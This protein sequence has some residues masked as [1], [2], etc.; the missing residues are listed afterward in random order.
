M[1]YSWTSRLNYI[2]YNVMALMAFCGFLNH[3]SVKY[4]HL[5]GL[6]EEPL[7]LPE[8]GIKFELTEID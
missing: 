2:L 1:L 3:V 6:A 8:D 4:A 5:I 7:G